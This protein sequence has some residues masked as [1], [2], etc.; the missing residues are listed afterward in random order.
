MPEP[1]SYILKIYMPGSK[2]YRVIEVPGSLTLEELHQSIHKYM[3]FPTYEM[4][5][6]FPDNKL[7]SSSGY[8]APQMRRRSAAGVRLEKLK[9]RPEQRILYVYDMEKQY[10]FYIRVEEIHAG[11]VQEVRLL[12]RGGQFGDGPGD[13]AAGGEE[14]PP[15]SWIVRASDDPMLCFIAKNEKNALLATAYSMNLEVDSDMRTEPLA[16][17][18]LNKIES[19]E[20]VVLRM[21]STEGLQTLNTVWQ[22]KDGEAVCLSYPLLLQLSL[23][24][25]VGLTEN[26]G[27]RLVW[28]SKPGKEW[29]QALLKLP[30]NFFLIDVYS[31]W[32]RIA[33]GI[34]NSY[35]LVL[36]DDFYRMMEKYIGGKVDVD[37]MCD[38]M[39]QR[40]EW[41]EGCQALQDGENWYWSTVDPQHAKRIL[42]RRL[43]YDLDYKPLTLREI[44]ENGESAGWQKIDYGQEL[45]YALEGIAKSPEEATEM[46]GRIV[47]AFVEGL[48]PQEI[49][50]TCLPPPSHMGR[51][52]YGRLRHIL[53]GIRRRL[54]DYGLKGYTQ[55]EAE[56][57]FPDRFIKDGFTVIRGGLE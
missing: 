11:Y 26:D 44:C 18:I 17:A 28:Y 14:L 49:I 53:S 4:Y 37:E 22:T 45:Q 7:F 10:E 24:G 6:F 38:F 21:L 25:F 50:E 51:S 16:E 42:S 54:P 29:F 47:D 35:G 36:M 56:S 31:R 27:L 19:D 34:L 9:L 15:D 32:N 2:L 3:G 48:E 5:A 55:A 12:R 46:M 52:A 40:M 43:L 41:N 33:R 20:T 13:S 57:M 1:E 8:Y 23:L 30:A 39:M